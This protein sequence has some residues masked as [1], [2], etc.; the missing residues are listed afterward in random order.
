MLLASV[1]ALLLVPVAADVTIAT[2]DGSTSSIVWSTE[3]D[4]VMGGQ[5]RSTFAV[6]KADSLGVWSGQVRI[7]PFLHAAGF[8]TCRGDGHVPDLSS[9][10]GIAIDLLAVPGKTNITAFQLQFESSDKG[11]N[12]RGGSFLADFSLTPSAQT[13]SLFVPF[14][15]FTEDFRGQKIGG[16]PSLKQLASIVQIGV[17]AAGTAGNFDVEMKSIVATNSAPAPGPPPS[18]SPSPSDG[19]L[20]VSFVQGRKDEYKWFV[21][22]DP[23]M[24]GLSHATFAEDAANEVGVFNGTVA[25]VP[26]LKAPGFCNAE[27]RPG[28]FGQKIPDVS[29]FLAG[30]LTYK[31][32]SK[33]P[34]SVFKAAFGTSTQYNFGSYKADFEVPSTGSIETVFIPFANF[35]NQWSASTGE[36]TKKCSEHKEVCPTAKALADIGSVG[37]WAEGTAGNFHVEISS[38]A[39]TH[40]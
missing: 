30:G 5:S 17:G 11:A 8:C 32:A 22:N 1:A 34:M 24:G 6:D 20:L 31:L 3:D 16:P 7:V 9:Y 10:K 12:S 37:I 25:I 2:W 14:S 40:A 29:G 28:L 38:I 19:T 27:A 35:S 39:A 36:P 23:V 21:V 26:S 15:S 13:Q 18:P 33:G 4:P